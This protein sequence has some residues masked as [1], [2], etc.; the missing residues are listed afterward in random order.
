[1]SPKSPAPARCVATATGL[2]RE[3]TVDRRGVEPRSPGCR[4]GV[5]PLDQ[6]P[7]HPPRFQRSARES[8]SVH[9][10]TTEAYRRRTRGPPC[11]PPLTRIVPEGVEP[12][13]P[14]C[15]RGIVAVGPRDVA[16]PDRFH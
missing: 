3:R 1:M 12:P 6:P 8:N 5:L 11:A 4:P 13:S 2:G 15:K 16:S 14:L 9:L 10:L 7:F